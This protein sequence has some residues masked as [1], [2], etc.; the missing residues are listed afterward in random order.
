M[1]TRL[2]VEA[3]AFIKRGSGMRLASS[4]ADGVAVYGFQ[5][6]AVLIDSIMNYAAPRGMALRHGCK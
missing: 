5:S 1:M 3:E 2:F 6:D 4:G